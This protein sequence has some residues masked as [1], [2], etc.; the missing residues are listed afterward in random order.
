MAPRNIINDLYAQQPKMSVTDSK[1][2][3]VIL[4]DP[5][6]VVNMTIAALAK[7][8]QVSEASVSRFCRNLNREGF[9]QVKI[10]LAQT[11][12]DQHN[13]YH[14]IHADSL[15]QALE[16]I[17]ANKTAEV[18]ATLKAA[19]TAEVEQMLTWL[20]QAPVIQ[21]AGAGGTYP[22]AL[23]AVYKFNQLGFL[24]LSDATYETSMAQTMNLPKN[25]V[26]LVISNSG[27]TSN[28]INQAQYAKQHGV[29][30]IALTNREDSPLGKLADAHVLTAVRQQVFESEYYFSRLS[31]TA[32]IETL[33]LLILAQDPA[34]SDHI[35]AHEH[36]IADAKI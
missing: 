11:A 33:F 4:A 5:S 23:D 3:Q 19:D 8:A 6:K 2:A 34:Y 9:H 24:A 14:D 29:H 28:L 21:C 1:I 10:E 30:V 20:K 7:S 15:T 12:E 25:S 32:A 27:E 16:N 31:A 13:Y 18:D 36:L 17:A 26:L 35:Q 22:V